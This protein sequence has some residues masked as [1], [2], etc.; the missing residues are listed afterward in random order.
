VLVEEKMCSLDVGKVEARISEYDNTNFTLLT[1][2]LNFWMNFPFQEAK[3]DLDDELLALKLCVWR[4]LRDGSLFVYFLE[5]VA[6]CD[7]GCC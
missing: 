2:S 7:G 3:N 6:L 1:S 4:S 5:S